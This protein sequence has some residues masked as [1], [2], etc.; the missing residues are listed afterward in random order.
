MAIPTGPARRPIFAIHTGVF[1]EWLSQVLTLTL[2]DIVT[3]LLK[4]NRFSM[5]AKADDTTLN[6]QLSIGVQYY[7]M[8]WILQDFLL[9]KWWKMLHKRIE[10]NRAGLYFCSTKFNVLN[11]ILQHCTWH[12]TLLN[13]CWTTTAIFIDQQMLNHVSPALDWNT[14]FQRYL[15]WVLGLKC[16]KHKVG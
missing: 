10:G 6:T 3:Q 2:N 11:G 4:A 9:N 1:L 15:K 13:I 8:L 12:D 5:D 16:E 14:V 7:G